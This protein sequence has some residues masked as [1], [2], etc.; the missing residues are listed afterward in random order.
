MEARLRNSS[1]RTLLF[2]I[3]TIAICGIV[4][5]LIIAGVS[6]YLLGNSVTQF[7]LVIGF[8]MSAMGLGSF[9]SRFVKSHLLDFFIGV[10]ITI[11]LFGGFSAIALFYAFGFKTSY[12]VI[13]FL[14]IIIIGVMVGFEIPILTRI[15]KEHESELRIALANVLSF[16]YIGALL[17]SVAFP[18]IL[19]PRFGLIKT[20]FLIGCLNVVVAFAVYL[21]YRRQLRFKVIY[22]LA[23]LFV[24]V[25]L[26]YGFW[27][28][29]YA[30]QFLEQ[31]LYSDK[32]IF[33]TQTA[34]QK[35]VLTQ[36]K[37]D[38]RLF[39]NGNLQ[40]SS[41]DEYRY[42]EA[43]VHPAMMFSGRRDE[44]LVLGGGDGLAMRELL[45]YTDVEHFTL[46]DLDAAVTGLAKKNEH[47]LKLNNGSLNNP[48]VQVINTDAYQFMQNTTEMYNVIIVDLPDPNSESLN[49]LYT[50]QFYFLLEKHLTADGTI[51]VQST[52]PYFAPEA[53]WCVVKTV[54]AAGLNVYPYHVYVPSFGDWGYTLATR[55]KIDVTHFRLPFK[56]RYLN[57]ANFIAMFA[58][59]EDDLS[60]REKVEPNHMSR[61]VLLQYYEKGWQHW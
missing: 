6:S 45:R 53:F 46:V 15:V 36:G 18:L 47:F 42:H 13:M 9:L 22:F 59:G 39:I 14:F 57:E 29:R 60:Y 38:F 17:G 27:M 2:A 49:K 11:G 30:E 19:L 51:V 44:V 1:T 58:F 55:R 41:Y 4:Y 12:H 8:F 50:S 40:F 37:N 52:S 16:D 28:S 61:P 34:Y 3:F 23:I 5:E 31:K 56:M 48:R 35:I 54:A 10:E 26:I 43:L 33:S 21:H 24:A 32:I 20:A 25:G 7:S